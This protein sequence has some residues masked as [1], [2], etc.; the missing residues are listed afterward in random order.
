MPKPEGLISISVSCEGLAFSS[1]CTSTGEKLT[2][3]LELRWIT[4]RPVLR[5]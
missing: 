2:I 5:S 3:S 1:P 4:M